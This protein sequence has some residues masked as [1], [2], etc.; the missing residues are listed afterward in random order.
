MKGLLFLPVLLSVAFLNSRALAA[1]YYVNMNCTNPVPPYIG[2]TTAATN[3]QDAIDASMDGDAIW[4]TNGVYAFGGRDAYGSNRV[5]VTKA[6]TVQSVNGFASTAILGMTNGANVRCAFLTNGAALIGFTLTNGSS[7]GSYSAGGALSS[8][9]STIISNCLITGNISSDGGGGADG[10][11]YNCIITG[12]YGNSGG[13]VFASTMYNCVV[14]SNSAGNGGGCYSGTAY[15]CR[16]IGNTAGNGGG[17]YNS[18]FRNCLLTGNAAT[19]SFGGGGAYQSSLVNCTV[20][21]NRCTSFSGGIVGGALNC[22]SC[23]SCIIYNNTSLS[24]ATAPN[25]SGGGFLYNCCT[26][27][28]PVNGPG[29]FSFDP[30]LAN[31]AGGDFHLQSNSPCINAGNNS[32]G[33]PAS[34]LDLDGNPRLVGGTVDVGAYEYQ[35]PVSL[36]SYAWLQQYGLPI[37]AGTDAADPDS[38]G[39]SNWQEWIA[40]TDPTAPQSVLKMLLAVPTNNPTGVAL[41]WQSVNTRTYYLQRASNPAAQSPFSS[42]QSNI[43]GQVGTTSY[44]DT[45]LTGNGPFLYRVGVQ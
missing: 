30:T 17:G 25:Y 29:N 27:P 45:N 13:G 6:V 31:P 23:I 20:V 43:A 34:S 5:A 28:V 11:F 42:I 12:N 18:G 7:A 33:F 37:N 19:G 44:M 8:S 21:G 39:M 16:F 10:T 4:V 38:D 35:S 3:I 1:T 36:I 15:N 22:G 26:T 24:H 40:G 9:S 14:S 32:Y 41:T 2:W